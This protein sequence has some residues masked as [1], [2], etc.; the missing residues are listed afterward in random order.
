ML[1]NKLRQS[2]FNKGHS[3]KIPTVRDVISINVVRIAV[4]S[5]V[6]PYFCVVDV[7]FLLLP[8]KLF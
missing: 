8:L 3:K 6:C 5:S 1:S 4:V 7:N 2:N